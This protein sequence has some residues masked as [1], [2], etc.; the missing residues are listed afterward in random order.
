[1]VGL[2][3]LEG[4]FQTKLFHDHEY[5]LA[6]SSGPNERAHGACAGSRTLLSARDSKAFPSPSREMDFS[7]WLPGWR[8]RAP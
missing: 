6:P 5:N 1:M 7:L 3:G 4:L 8:A 2:G